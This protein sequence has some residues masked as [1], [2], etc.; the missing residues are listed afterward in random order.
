[1]LHHTVLVIAIGP[2]LNIRKN[3]SSHFII[4][5][6]NCWGYFKTFPFTLFLKSLFSETSPPTLLAFLTHIS[7]PHFF[8]PT[9]RPL[10]FI[11]L[12]LNTTMEPISW[13]KSVFTFLTQ[14]QFYL[15]FSCNSLCLSNYLFPS[16]LSIHFFIFILLLQEQ[17]LNIYSVHHFL[18]WFFTP[19]YADFNSGVSHFDSTAQTVSPKSN[20]Y[21]SC[22]VESWFSVISTYHFTTAMSSPEK[23][24]IY[25]P[26]S[27]TLYLFI[28]YW[29]PDNSF[30]PEF[31]NSLLHFYQNP[32][33][34]SVGA[35]I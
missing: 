30:I 13:F 26:W 27:S 15:Q 25:T 31:S 35:L 22:L 9:F 6:Q 18:W 21:I 11:L 8:P 4:L 17:A 29:F 34:Y 10:T 12:W 5:F 33:H 7:N 2:G 16:F 32:H 14:S 3:N 19:F 1:M 23:I 24:V 20:C 28:L